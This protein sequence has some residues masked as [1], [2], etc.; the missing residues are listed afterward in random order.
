MQHWTALLDA[1]VLYSAGVRDVLLRLADRGLFRPLWTAQI[2]DEWIRNLISDRPE[3]TAAKLQRTRSKMDEYFPEALVT[4][5]EGLIPRLDLPDPRDRH[6]LA[7]AICAR[8]DAIVTRNL[9]DFPADRLT[10]HGLQAQHP[11]EFVMGLLDAQLGDVL[12]AVRDHRTALR[13]PPRSPEEHLAA[14]ESLGLARSVSMLRDYM[15]AI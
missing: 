10:P 14:L 2:H 11:D 1:N 4:G 15:G 6:V 9:R 8:A 3:L 12:A 13:N 5:Y 7:A